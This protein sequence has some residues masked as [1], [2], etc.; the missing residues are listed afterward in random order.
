MKQAIESL[1]NEDEASLQL[2]MQE[3]EKQ[4]QEL[5]IELKD[6]E[7]GL[8]PT[9]VDKVD[10]DDSAT[11]LRSKIAEVKESIE[12]NKAKNEKTE[13]ENQ[14]ME[15]EMEELK[16]SQADARELQQKLL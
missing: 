6:I 12:R 5:K 7:K 11:T 2:A 3:L 4:N 15:L 10:L 14:E 1:R 13:A 9:L 8:G 16:D